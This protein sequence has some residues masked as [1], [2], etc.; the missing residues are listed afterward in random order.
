MQNQVIKNKQIDRIISIL[1]QEKEKASK[2]YFEN[3]IKAKPLGES[4]DNVNG[5][6]DHND[7]GNKG[8]QQLSPIEAI[9]HRHM[10]KS[11]VTFEDYYQVP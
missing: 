6:N 4:N 2:E 9:F 11:L 8:S 5:A 3:L 7:I 10:K 1:Q